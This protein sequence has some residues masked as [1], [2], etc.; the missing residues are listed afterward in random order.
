MS[1]MQALNTLMVFNESGDA[2]QLAG[3]LT[4]GGEGEIHAVLD[5]PR[6]LVKLYHPHI[7]QTRGAQLRDKI[8]CMVSQKQHFT[9]TTLGWPQFS[10]VDAKGNWLGYAMRRIEGH[11]MFSMANP[12]LFEKQ[13]PTLNRLD[14]SLMMQ[15]L[16]QQVQQLHSQGVMIGD[17]NLRNFMCHPA[18]RRVGLIDCDSYQLT[19]PQHF[20]CLVGTPEFSP[21]EHQQQAYG[22]L[23]RTL[24]SEAFSLAVI[25]FKCLMRGRHPYDQVGGGTPVSN[26]QSGLFPYANEQGVPPGQWLGLWHKLPLY[27]RE[28][29][30]Q[31]FGLGANHPAHRPTLDQWQHAFKQY[32]T[33]LR[34]GTLSPDI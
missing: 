28:L 4:K 31:T 30:K 33:D 25:L 18:T 13:F 7:V 10:V 20:P 24:A 9:S 5:T 6:A 19:N 21:P 11:S 32:V 17:Y 22:H 12:A 1:A 15:S 23:T 34:Q 27:V 14:I 16:V 29:F 3:L 2:R 8:A 26:M